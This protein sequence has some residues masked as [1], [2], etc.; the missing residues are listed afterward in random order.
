M[1]SNSNNFTNNIANN[2]RSGISI[3]NSSYNNLEN[4]IASNNSG[5][6]IM[7]AGSYNT[8]KNNDVS[9][10]SNGLRISS[11]NR[12]D[13]IFSAAINNSIA[14]NNIS[15]NEYGI[16]LDYS[17]NNTIT[18]NK[19][20][21]NKISGLAL[22]L[23]EPVTND[24][25]MI[26]TNQMTISNSSL[27][28]NGGNIY[29]QKDSVGIYDNGGGGG[30][31]DME[32][33]CNC[34]YNII[35]TPYY[36][37]KD[38]VVLGG[39]WGVSGIYRGY[40]V[41][42]TTTVQSISDT[43]IVEAGTFTNVVRTR[44]TRSFPNG[45]SQNDYAN[46]IDR[47]YA[48]NVGLIKVKAYTMNGN[49]ISGEL[50]E[51]HVSMPSGFNYF[52]MDTGDNWKYKW[53]MYTSVNLRR[54]RIYDNQ[55]NNI[56]N[57][58][59]KNGSINRWNTTKTLST[60]IIGGPYL[61]GN[62]WTTPTG[63]G[64]SQTCT[65]SDNDG[66]CDSTYHLD[67][68]NTDNFPLAVSLIA[69]PI[70]E[71]N[72]LKFKD[73]NADGIQNT[74]EPVISG[75]NFTIDDRNGV[76]VCTGSTDVSGT[77]SCSIDTALYPPPY[78]LTEELKS[79]WT[80]T[81]PNPVTLFPLF[82]T[83][84]VSFGNMIIS[85]E[86]NGT[87]FNDSNG[88]GIRDIDETALSG[89][90]IKLTHLISPVNEKLIGITT[91]DPNGEYKFD[92]LL[93]GFYKVEE[94]AIPNW[95]QTY[96]ASGSPH[97]FYLNEAEIKTGVD[98]GNQEI[99][100]AEIRGLKFNDSNGNGVQDAGESGMSGINIC[101]SPSW[102][103]TITE[104]GDYNFTGITPGTYTVYESMPSGYLATTPTMVTVTLNSGDIM[105]VNFGNRLPV[106]PPADVSIPQQYSTQNGIPTVLRP[107][108]TNLTIRKNLSGILNNVV[109]INLTLKW[110]DGTTK[111][112]NMEQIDSTNVWITNISQPFPP[113][114]AQMRFEV[115]VAPAGNWPGPEDALEIGDI[116]FIDPSGIIRSS[117]TNTPINGATATLLKE[118]P[119]TTGNFEISPSVNQIPQT[120]PQITGVDG[121]Y[122]WLTVPG[123]YKVR[124]ERPGYVMN[125]SL[126]VTVPPAV[127]NLNIDLIPN[128]SFNDVSCSFWGYSYI[129]YLKYHGVTSGYP[130][131]TFKPG[132]SITRAEF[133]VI[134]TRARSLTYTGGLSDFPDVP[135]SHWAYPY[136][137]AAKQ[138]G[139]ISGYPDG[140]FKPDN[141]VTR[142][143]I[144]VMIS[145]AMSWSY[146]NGVTDFSDVPNT[147]WSYPYVMA[148]KEYGVVSGY[149]DGTFKPDNQANRA[150]S[151]VMTERMMIVPDTVP[152]VITISSPISTTYATHII[153]LNVAA[154]EPTST[155]LYSL[156]GA[157]NVSFTPNTTITAAEGTNSIIVYASDIAG[158]W[159][160]K[161]ASF[162]VDTMSD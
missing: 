115:D 101:L 18:R 98:F 48:P 136:V 93:P 102:R 134:M 141:L 50:K 135:S 105:T 162:I 76:I 9:N 86:I 99:L 31:F 143:E 96:P 32:F 71:I 126:P 43:I 67:S 16:Y 39:T 80:S 25:S 60:N 153:P 111:T 123:L 128:P 151:S 82:S 13:Y 63:T 122:G 116:I 88:N 23:Y 27:S 30:Q 73:L 7:I 46:N 139:I 20:E 89:V 156:N 53:A 119:P 15:N 109:S 129:E 150:E 133:A 104:N 81:T 91:T 124:A 110:I 97:N 26:S 155:W 11:R 69:P 112:A 55:F 107:G 29:F 85:G 19:I 37:L 3:I 83:V 44:Q 33:Y 34:I 100:P 12:V 52:P 38:P 2:D 145:R 74:S 130:D 117:C 41:T 106:P 51:Y 121:K 159:N 24:V 22:D 6:G 49:Y 47:W 87:K 79:G 8:V 138:N 154:N 157:A 160:S 54:N 62:A 68:N 90:R 161:A 78:N 45:Y 103:C 125:E 59:I 147:H 21:L 158:N 42:S 114:T 146:T 57:F 131:G 66:I 137:M 64:F 75:W 140:T 95:S 5:N 17:G 127:E 61:S 14:D 94:L 144:S 132:N 77:F 35:Y 56:N 4:N 72:I 70:V 58:I 36:I 142:A 28:P 149:P 108:L 120:N 152:P 92:H 65:D 40:N 118:W 10:N 1:D 113:G 84:N 148:V